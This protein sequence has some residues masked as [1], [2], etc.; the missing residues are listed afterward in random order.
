M[1]DKVRLK[2]E[3]LQWMEG[4]KMWQECG[5]SKA[6]AAD[7]RGSLSQPTVGNEERAA[8][9]GIWDDT[10]GETNVRLVGKGY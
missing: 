10:V 3:I 9:G 6:K 4:N 1:D 8:A 5:R 2:A 7:R